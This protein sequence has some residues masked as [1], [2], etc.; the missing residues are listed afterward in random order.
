MKIKRNRLFVDAINIFIF[1]LLLLRIIFD[2]NVGSVNSG[3]AGEISILALFLMVYQAVVMIFI[4]KVKYTD[5]I[6]WFILLEFVFLYGRI[7]VKALGKDDLIAWHLFNAFDDV[8]CYKAAL[9]CLAYSQAV[10]LGCFLLQSRKSIRKAKRNME[11]YPPTVMYRIGWSFFAITFPIKLYSN[12]LMIAAQRTVGEYVA[13]GVTNGF[14]AAVSFLPV[15]GLLLVLCSK[16]LS[17]TNVKRVFCVYLIYEVFYMVF[18]GDRRQDFIGILTWI[19]CYME[20]YNVKMNLRKILKY[21]LF[22]FVV[23]IFLA[24]IRTGR[25]EGF[26]NMSNF[27]EL[28]S[29][30]AQNDLLVETLGEFGGTFFTVTNVIRYY[31]EKLFY[32]KGLSLLGSTLIIIPGIMTSLFPTLFYYTEIN[33]RCKDFNGL[34]TGG[35]L[36]QDMYANWGL[37]GLFFTVIAGMIIAKVMTRD[38]KNLCPYDTAMYYARFYILMNLVRAGTIELGRPLAYTYLLVYLFGLFYRR[39]GSK[40][41]GG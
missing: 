6:L 35:S 5:F 23:L 18:S 15:I 12:L 21:I 26:N 4:L 24:T 32:L 27:V 40:K 34:A 25:S 3:W 1:M 22:A 41:G 8:T 11:L 9:F 28:F 16:K 29:E 17:K 38:D 19:L 20:I 7:W 39:I 14:I 33:Y 30:V 13:T 2:W 37:F 36:P 31:P 10:F